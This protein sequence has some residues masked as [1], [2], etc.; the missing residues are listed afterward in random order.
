MC[1][2]RVQV[3]S[4]SGEFIR[5][6]GMGTLRAP[7]SIACAAADRLIIVDRDD[8]ASYGYYAGSK[9][10]VVVMNA[11]DGSVVHAFGY[12]GSGDGQFLDSKGVAVLGGRIFVADGEQARIQAF[13]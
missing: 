4:V 7:S 10:C 1:V 8:H 13:A 3:W 9:S 11:V 6:M 2:C 12:R 5:S